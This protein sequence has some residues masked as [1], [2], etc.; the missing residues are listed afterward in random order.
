[1]GPVSKTL[2]VRA[3]VISCLS[4]FE[5]V[6]YSCK[7]Q[8]PARPKTTPALFV[9]PG[10]RPTAISAHLFM[11][12]ALACSASGLM[13]SR[14]RGKNLGSPFTV[15]NALLTHSLA[16]SLGTYTDTSSLYIIIWILSG[17]QERVWLPPRCA[18]CRF[19]QRARCNA[20]PFI[21]DDT[22]LH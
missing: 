17:S 11:F 15:S 3:R 7:I 16:H 8:I 20:A 12:R 10:R 19:Y 14:K 5:A 21:P 18:F 13:P 22:F 6:K 4:L 9:I 1:M 2:H